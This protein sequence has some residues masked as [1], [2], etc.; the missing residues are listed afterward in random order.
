MYNPPAFKESDT[1]RLL[2]QVD[3]CGLA[4][5]ITHGS[6]GLRANHVPLLLTRNGD[7]AQLQG[8]LAKANPQWRD[9]AAGAPALVVFSGPDAY[10]SPGFYPSKAQNP[11]VVPTWNYVSVQARGTAQ[12]FDE[13]E[14][15]HALVAALTRRHEAQRPKPWS[16]GDAPAAYIQ[17]MLQAI[18]GFSILIEHIEGKRKLSQNRSAVDEQGVRTAL[19][20]SARPSDNALAD[21][22]SINPQPYPPME[23]QS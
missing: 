18:V 4:L 10:V 3:S 13:P 23:T 2:A 9:L 11:S 6:E 17:K 21:A 19:A 1:E 15:L 14:R 8:H 12:T 5:L 16:I 7:Q 20:Q 22:M